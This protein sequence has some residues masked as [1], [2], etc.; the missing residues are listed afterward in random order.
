MPDQR[1]MLE[2]FKDGI[3]LA[4]RET[5]ESLKEYEALFDAVDA[6]ARKLPPK[7]FSAM[8]LPSLKRSARDLPAMRHGGKRPWLHWR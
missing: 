1:L 8:M 4:E 3:A 7:I 5:P 2:A 6:K